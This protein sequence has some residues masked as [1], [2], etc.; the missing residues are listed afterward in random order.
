M[1]KT[2]MHT[3]PLG[4]NSGSNALHVTPICLGSMTWGQQ[5]SES[6][7]HAQLDYAISRGINFIDTAEMY[8][9]PARAE[10]YGSTERIIGSWLAAKGKVFREK[11]IIASKCAGPSRNASDVTW[12]RGKTLVNAP[13]FS[14]AD[15]AR[16]VRESLK[17]LQTDYIDLYQLHWPAR[18]VPTFGGYYF[19]ATAER[20]SVALEETLAALG[21][22]V[23]AGRVRAV[24]VSN[25]TPWGMMQ[26]LD[27]A[28]RLSLPR[29]VSTQNAFSLLNRVYEY[30][31]SEIGFREN[32]GLLAY[33]PLAFGHLTGKYLRKPPANSR[34]QLFPQFGR[35]N[36]PGVVP[37][38]RAYDALAR[39]SGLTLT[40]LALA[41]CKSRFYVAS[42]IIGATTLTQLKENIDA[43]EVELSADVLKRIDEIH[44]LHTNPA[45]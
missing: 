16:G 8:S 34:L 37:A 29:I 7:G 12:V 15:I 3:R 14:K 43:F 20:E 26:C 6:E 45:P 22:E 2:S 5:N 42:T 32:V 17:R 31:L 41:F 23:K 4:S 40:Q 25:E 33:S 13:V 9:V 18:N 28:K 35:Y 36:K 38:V 21:E 30:G 11:V 10:T 19:D 24:G 39:E 44:L 27:I 1:Q